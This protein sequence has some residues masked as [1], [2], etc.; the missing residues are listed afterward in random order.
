MTVGASG[1]SATPEDRTARTLHAAPPTPQPRPSR[2]VRRWTPR[3]VRSWRSGH[4]GQSVVEFALILPVL[5]LL[6]LMAVD[7]GRLFFSYVQVV[8]AAREA[9]NNA[10]A[11][12]RYVQNGTMTAT[13]Y[14]AGI[15]NAAVQ[16]TNAQA[17]RGAEASLAVSSPACFTPANASIACNTA[18]Q[19]STT[20]TGVGNSV[21]VVVTQPFTFFTP[22]IGSFFGGSL[23]LSASATAPVLNPLVAK[24][25]GNPTP[26]PTAT[27]TPTPSPTPTPTPSPTPTGSPGPTPTPSPTPTPTPSPT[28][29]MCKVPDLVGQ[30]W[31]NSGGVLGA[32][33]TWQGAGFT[34][35]LTDTGNNAKQIKSQNL[36]PYVRNPNKGSGTTVPCS[37]SMDVSDKN[38]YTY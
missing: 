5:M 30:Y 15:V 31:N 2:P 25:T 12:A 23:N 19:D 17:Q 10:A 3:P 38:T 16:E 35:T 29:A 11:E 14:Y 1:R 8:N 20:A 28:I 21:K 18:P 4:R 22:F 37:S 6:L 32:L 9:A 13:D 33:A 26:T 24:I 7:F 27:P 34:G 36:Q